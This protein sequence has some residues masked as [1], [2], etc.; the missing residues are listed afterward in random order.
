MQLP[1]YVQPAVAS[2]EACNVCA[3]TNDIVMR[4]DTS[5]EI[6]IYTYISRYTCVCT[7]LLLFLPSS[8]RAVDCLG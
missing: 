8:F 7:C 1:R 3:E 5:N 2:A 4:E 6:Q